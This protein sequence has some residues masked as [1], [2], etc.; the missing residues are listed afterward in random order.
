MIRIHCSLC[1]RELKTND[2]CYTIAVGIK[3]GTAEI[4][5]TM[6]CKECAKDNTVWQAIATYIEMY[7]TATVEE[8]HQPC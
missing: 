3:G 7:H 1:T 8:A 6:I 4:T 5:R 2:V